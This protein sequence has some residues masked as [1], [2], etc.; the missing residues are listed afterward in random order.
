[1]L[2]TDRLCDKDKDCE[3]A[4]D[5]DIVCVSEGEHDH[6]SERLFMLDRVLL[7]VKLSVEAKVR[8]EVCVIE[9]KDSDADSRNVAVFDALQ[10]EVRLRDE[11]DDGEMEILI[12]NDWLALLVSVR[13]DVGIRVPLSDNVPVDSEADELKLWLS[14]VVGDPVICSVVVGLWESE[15]VTFGE[16]DTLCVPETENDGFDE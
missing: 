5:E 12:E 7:D 6:E 3:L 13:L 4:A 9:E 11:L 10:L 16:C 2:L 14:D 1:M 15:T 8:V